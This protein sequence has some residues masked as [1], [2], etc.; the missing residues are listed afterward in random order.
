M[1]TDLHFVV[2]LFGDMFLS[3]NI[4]KSISEVLFVMFLSGPRSCIRAT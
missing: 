2:T 3:T 4:P 1:Y